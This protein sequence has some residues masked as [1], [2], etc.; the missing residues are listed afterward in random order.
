M[1]NLGRYQDITTQAAEAGGVDEWIEAIKKAA[2]LKGVGI[3]AVG[4]LAATG[5]AAFAVSRYQA[6]KKARDASA[7]EAEERLKKSIEGEKGL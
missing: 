4:A 2:Q 5:V 3:G 7:N 1:S 6:V